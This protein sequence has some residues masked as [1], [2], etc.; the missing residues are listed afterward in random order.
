M[1]LHIITSVLLVTFCATSAH[2]RT[3]AEQKIESSQATFLAT[4]MGDSQGPL[5]V[6]AAETEKLPIRTVEEIQAA[7]EDLLHS[8]MVTVADI[9]D[10]CREKTGSYVGNEASFECLQ[11]ETSELSVIYEESMAVLDAKLE[12]ASE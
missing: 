5:M 4:R 7:K 1:K 2:A 3:F 10:S 6:P 11:S 12:A 8:W 9:T